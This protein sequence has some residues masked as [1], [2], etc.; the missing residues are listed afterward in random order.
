MAVRPRPG[1]AGPGLQPAL[2]VREGAR[3][4]P[5]PG[6]RGLLV[7]RAPGSGTWSETRRSQLWFGALVPCWAVL[8]N[9]LV[10]VC[11]LVRRACPAA[12]W[13]EQAPPCYD[14]AGPL[15]KVLHP[16]WTALQG[17]AEEEPNCTG[18]LTSS[19]LFVHPS[20]TPATVRCWCQGRVTSG[21]GRGGLAGGPNCSSLE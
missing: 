4:T 11:A 1:H 2:V 21:G 15:E 13:S 19:C 5:V 12:S 18:R 9:L 6:F 14:A 7:V 20:L 8:K 16:L 17:L 10:S 3:H